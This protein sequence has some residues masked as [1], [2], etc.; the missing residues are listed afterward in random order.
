VSTGGAQLQFA[1][2]FAVFLVALAGLSFVVLRAELLVDGSV[3]R[4]A[5]AAGLFAIGAAAFLHGALIVEDVNNGWLVALR[6]VG[7]ALLAIV[8]TGWLAGQGGRVWLIAGI[9]LLG[10]SEL[11]VRADN[12]TLG[13]WLRIAAALGLG[14]AFLAAG[15]RSIATRVPS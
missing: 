14:A 4:F 5:F 13:N 10:A 8:P 7:I 11:A 1:A 15:R 3:R 9:V 12:Q 2:D 6:V